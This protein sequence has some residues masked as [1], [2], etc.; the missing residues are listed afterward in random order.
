MNL[1]VYIKNLAFL[2]KVNRRK[3]FLQNDNDE[4]LFKKEYEKILPAVYPII[5]KNSYISPC[6]RLV[7]SQLN[8]FQFSKN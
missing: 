3:P 5:N 7:N 4:K 6:G 2:Q 8:I 1:C